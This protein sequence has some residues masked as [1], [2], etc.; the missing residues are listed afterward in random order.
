MWRSASDAG[1]TYCR[2]RTIEGPR[3]THAPSGQ[4]G[5]QIRLCG[6]ELSGGW[7][8]NRTE[9]HGFAGRCIPIQSMPYAVNHASLPLGTTFLGQTTLP[10]LYYPNPT[11]SAV[12]L[13]DTCRARS[14]ELA[15]KMRAPKTSDYFGVI[16][17][18][19]SSGSEPSELI[20][21]GLLVAGYG[22]G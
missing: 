21:H 5:A 4:A 7:T 2:K 13:G 20:H 18:H 11:T 8:R 15:R 17:H 10:R 12:I 1:A 6:E 14:P 3:A 9:V 22:L 16:R 19:S